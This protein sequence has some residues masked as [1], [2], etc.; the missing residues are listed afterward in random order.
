MIAIYPSNQQ[1]IVSS[2]RILMVDNENINYSFG[3]KWFVLIIRVTGRYQFR[4]L[5]R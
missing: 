3:Y 1:E 2:I 4:N 5:I